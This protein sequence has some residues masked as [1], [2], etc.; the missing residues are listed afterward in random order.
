M[1]IHPDQS[2][3]WWQCKLGSKIHGNGQNVSSKTLAGD[4]TSPYINGRK[5]V[6]PL[7][8]QGFIGFTW[9]IM[10]CCQITWVNLFPLFQEHPWDE[11][12]NSK[13]RIFPDPGWF[14][15]TPMAGS[16]K[17]RRMLGRD[18]GWFSP[19]VLIAFYACGVSLRWLQHPWVP[20]RGRTTVA[21][22]WIQRHPWCC[23]CC[24][25]CCCCWLLVVVGCCWLL[26]VGCWLM[27]VGVVVVVVVVVAFSI[28]DFQLQEAMALR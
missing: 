19:A 4:W 16:R 24:C 27:V 17:S 6:S 2:Y 12:Q 3:L 28:P 8:L 21:R 10:P 18:S 14:E 22:N 9:F 5:L 23:C 11:I 13:I 20:K 25:C 1:M 15:E 26:V 7:K